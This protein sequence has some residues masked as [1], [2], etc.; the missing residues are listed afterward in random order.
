LQSRAE[1][2]RAEAEE[3]G[4]E[5]KKERDDQLLLLNAAQHL[6]K[7]KQSDSIFIFS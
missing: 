1:Q 7:E 3:E 4:F 2:S 5:R 6:R